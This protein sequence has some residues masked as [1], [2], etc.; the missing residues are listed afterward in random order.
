[1]KLSIALPIIAFTGLF[2]YGSYREASEGCEKWKSAGRRIEYLRQYTK[3]EVLKTPQA[4]QEIKFKKE[5]L[6]KEFASSPPKYSPPNYTEAIGFEYGIPGRDMEHIMRVQIK[7]VDDEVAKKIIQ[8]STANGKGVITSE[9]NRQCT[10]DQLS[11]RKQILGLEI[12][13]RIDT[14]KIY[15]ESPFNNSSWTVRK[16]FRY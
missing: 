10:I 4:Q 12:N 14:K 6:K 9:L 16:Y 7:S 13:Q 2:G 5:R 11:S 1:M 3:W 15:L 8:E